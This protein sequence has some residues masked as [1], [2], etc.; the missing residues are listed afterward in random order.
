MPADELTPKQAAFARAFFETGNAAEAYRQAYD[1]VQD[2]KDGW[3]YVE[4][5]QLLDHPKVALKLEELRKEADKLSIFTRTQ[6]LEELE[7]ARQLALK[8]K[9]ASAAVSAV[10]SKAKLFG[11]DRE[12]KLALTGKDGGPIQTL[13]LNELSDE[14]LAA[15]ASGS[16]QATSET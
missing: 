8:E 5:S 6:A 14:Q 13:N 10:S 3:L 1:V 12:T 7:E 2:A 9:Q 16:G 4:A 15:I 11:L